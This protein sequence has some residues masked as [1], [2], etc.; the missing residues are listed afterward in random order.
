MEEYS[1]S[2]A[3]GAS[4]WE[5]E[6]RRHEALVRWVVR[7]QWRGPLS[8]ADACQEGRL[9]L[10]RALL[11][12][13]PCRG[14]A[15]STY[16]VPAIARAIWRAV[17]AAQRPPPPARGDAED[18]P[19]C[20]APWIEPLDLPRLRGLLDALLA[21]L[22]PRPRH[23]LVAHYG[24]DGEPEQSL[25]QIARA[26]GVSRQRVGQLHREALVTLAHPAHSLALREFL[27]DPTRGDYRR[28]LARLRRQ[29]RARRHLRRRP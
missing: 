24:L 13:D 20:A 21:P 2:G 28:A 14:T 23:I 25:A 9:G 18:P 3:P 17:A 1:P 8:Y 19:T 5:E 16:A 22:A 6:M 10:W 15:F 7:R 4:A 26:W 12:Y 11:R 29:A 27:G